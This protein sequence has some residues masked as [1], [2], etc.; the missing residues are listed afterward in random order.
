[1]LRPQHGA[2]SYTV[3]L[4]HR[5]FAIHHHVATIDSNHVH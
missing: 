2:P 4:V 5:I 3:G 1:L